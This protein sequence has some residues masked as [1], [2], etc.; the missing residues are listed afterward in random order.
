V[1]LCKGRRLPPT[2]NF[3]GV[4]R[5]PP[6]PRLLFAKKYNWRDARASPR[7]QLRARGGVDRNP[8][9]LL[10]VALMFWNLGFTFN[11][12]TASFTDFSVAARPVM[13]VRIAR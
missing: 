1:E 3:R 6:L 12:G 4:I 9:R 10:A 8:P 11:L 13:Q 2:P 5:L 7:P